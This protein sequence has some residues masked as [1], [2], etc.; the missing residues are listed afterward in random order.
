M[1]NSS[2]SSS[3]SSSALFSY[4]E[5]TYC[6]ECLSSLLG[7]D[8]NDD[9][10]VKKISARKVRAEELECTE[11]AQ[12]EIEDSEEEEE[13]QEEDLFSE[14]MQEEDFI[15][16]LNQFKLSKKEM[17]E[18]KQASKLAKELAEKETFEDSEEEE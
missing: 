4:E 3:I 14:E 10:C 1:S 16:D 17:E 6:A 2:F 7:D 9:P 11:C 12:D 13:D 15:I 5:S 8:F 18:A